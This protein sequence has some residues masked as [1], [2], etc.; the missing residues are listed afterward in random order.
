MYPKNTCSLIA[1]NSLPLQVGSRYCK[2]ISLPDP[3]QY[4]VAYF[5]GIFFQSK[6]FPPR[7]GRYVWL[8]DHYPVATKNLIT[9]SVPIFCFNYFET[10]R[11]SFMPIIE[12]ED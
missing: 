4:Q 7:K 1:G 8:A 9:I 6:P 10:I 11:T 2:I 5:P 3:F 12:K